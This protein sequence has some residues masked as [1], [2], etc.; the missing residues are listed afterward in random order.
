MSVKSCPKCG[1][2]FIEDNLYWDG[3]NKG[4]KEDLAGL[5]CDVN[6]DETCI[7]ELKG[8]DH[9]G[10]T[11]Q[12]REGFLNGVEYELKRQLDMKRKLGDGPE[13]ML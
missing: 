5:V 6:G 4:K 11:W 13:F 9:N 10:D 12:K 7:N 2:K 8:T 1:A 3:G